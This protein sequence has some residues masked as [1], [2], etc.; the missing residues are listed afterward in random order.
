[1]KKKLQ[2]ALSA[3]VL[4]SSPVFTGN[5]FAAAWG[6]QPVAAEA[7]YPVSPL[8]ADTKVDTMYPS[9]AGDFLVYSTRTGVANYNVA[10]VSKYSLSAG[11]RNI[12][13]LVLN[14]A[15]RFGVATSDGAIGYVSDRVGPI[16]A[17]MW[18]GQGDGHVAIANM[19]TYRGGLAPLHLNA[20]RDGRVWCFDST[21]EANRYN[22]L[23]NEFSHVAD[24]EL[25]GQ[26]WRVYDH[27]NY[28]V[29][30]GYAATKAGNTNK[31]NPPVLFTFDR[32]SSQLVMI[33]NA[34]D[35][36]LSPDGRRIAFVRETNGN[37]DIWVQDV[38]GGELIQ[39]TNSPYGEFEPAWNADGSKLV[40]V[41]NR[42]SEGDVQKTSI[43]MMDL[44][45]NRVERLTNAAQATDGGPA[46]LDK[47]TVVFHSN[48]DP[49]KPQE[50]T[51]SGWNIW[52]LKLN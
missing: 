30:L 50:K 2:L 47:N 18:Q 49:K 37:Y 7:P 35:G 5:A 46:W 8:I 32:K 20:S 33:N 13:P 9:V 16:S 24:T 6:K 14:E 51:V 31:F 25:L 10:R 43:Y 28:R 44:K 39:L 48:R 12:T 22:Q 38:Q 27:D 34:F 26:Q 40:F 52:Q 21:F 42:D 3:A 4:I 17:W 15:I 11:E 41:S 1:M 45:N 29:K 19:A 36:A 23:L